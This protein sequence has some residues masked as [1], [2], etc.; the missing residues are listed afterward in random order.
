MLLEKVLTKIEVAHRWQGIL[1]ASKNVKTMTRAS[2][3]KIWHDGLPISFGIDEFVLK[4][5]SSLV[6][7]QAYSLLQ[8]I[9]LSNLHNGVYN[10]R[11]DIEK[12]NRIRNDIAHKYA[13]IEYRKC[14]ELVKIIEAEIKAWGLI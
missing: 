6:F 3:G 11:K 9:E 5:A 1:T 2:A 14:E 4:S 12:C 8:D 7:I 13:L 10:S